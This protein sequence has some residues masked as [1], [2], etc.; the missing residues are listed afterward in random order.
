MKFWVSCPFCCAKWCFI[1]FG[2]ERVA[3]GG[4]DVGESAFCGFCH[5]RGRHGS[6]LCWQVR[7]KVN[8]PAPRE[9]KN[10]TIYA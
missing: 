8:H 9:L 3:L 2:L 10:D 4:G 1:A 5:P 7:P 6:A